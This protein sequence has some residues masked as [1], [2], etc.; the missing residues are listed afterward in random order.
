MC[1][2]INSSSEDDNGMRMLSVGS[3]KTNIRVGPTLISE[4]TDLIT[5]KPDETKSRGGFMYTWRL[6]IG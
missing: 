5:Y 4:W 2:V 3:C 1:S 6:L